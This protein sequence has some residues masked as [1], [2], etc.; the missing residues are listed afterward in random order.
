[1]RHSTKSRLKR[2][3]KRRRPQR[4]RPSDYTAAFAAEICARIA[5]GKS[6][7]TICKAKDM[8]TCSTVFCW[9]AKHPDF[10]E[11]YGYAMEQRAHA[12][13]EEV[14]EIADNSSRDLQANKE[15]QRASCGAYPAH[16]ATHG[17]A[18]MVHREIRSKEIWQCGAE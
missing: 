13:F 1:M 7:R 9:L 16:Q 6:L 11:Q 12:I 18:Q 14:L 8:P 2:K 4:G 3:A 5:S 17:R 10:A 15:R